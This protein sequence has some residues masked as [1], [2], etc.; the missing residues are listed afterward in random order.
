[1]SARGI[2][3]YGTR[4]CGRGRRRARAE[5]SSLGSMPDLD[6]SKTPISPATKIGFQSRLAGDDALFQA[7]LRILERVARPHSR[8][9]GRGLAIKRIRFNGAEL[10]RG[11]T[12]VD[13]NMAEYWLKATERIM[14]DLD[15]TPE[16]KLKGV[17]SLFYDE[18]YQWWLTVEE[19]FQSNRLSWGFFKTT[20]ESKYMDASYVDARKR[21]LMNLMQCNRFV[22]EYEREREIA[23]LVE[24]T[25]IAE[26]VKRVEHHNRDRER[27]KNKKDSEPFSSVPR[28]KKKA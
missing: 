26:D 13:P 12:R 4:G 11:V 8:A 24:N 9:R 22:A 27:G 6:K 14:D 16:Q 19:G 28:S 3:G 5:C 23:V 2:R 18:A 7:I 25:K 10:F 21:E 1:M 20:F 17:V 15:C